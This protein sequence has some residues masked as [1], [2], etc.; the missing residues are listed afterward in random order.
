[1]EYWKRLRKSGVSD[2]LLILPGANVFIE[3]EKGEILMHKGY[4]HDFWRFIGGLAEDN[5]SL[6]QC[7]VREVKEETNLYV[8]NLVPFCFQDDPRTI[9]TVEES[10]CFFHTMSFW[11]KDYNGEII[12][13][14]NEVRDTKWIDFSKTDFSFRQNAQKTINAFLEWKQTGQFQYITNKGK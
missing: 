12:M 2:D 5:E 1:M 3:N 8:K 9:K 11:A 14:K 4:E 13:N 10:E 6:W 7:G